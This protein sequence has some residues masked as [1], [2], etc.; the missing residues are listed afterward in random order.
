MGNRL[1]FFVFFGALFCLVSLGVT[2]EAVV[3]KRPLQY[4]DILSNGTSVIRMRAG[5]Q[6]PTVLNF[7]QG[8]TTTDGGQLRIGSSTPVNPD[9][10]G[11]LVVPQGTQEVCV[12]SLPTC[13]VARRGQRLDLCGNA[14]AGDASVGD[15]SYQCCLDTA[16]TYSWNAGNCS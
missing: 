12:A 10:G 4:T 1:S 2:V 11:V 5:A 14:A 3:S 7:Q 13:V 8:A 9:L 6:I 16:G 15:R